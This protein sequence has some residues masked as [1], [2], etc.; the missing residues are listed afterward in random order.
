MADLNKVMLI[1]RLTRDPQLKYLPSQTAICEFGFAVGRQWSTPQGEKREETTFLDCSIFGK[2]AETFN[3]YMAKGRQV[4][5]E[6]RL[7]LDTWD[8]KTTGQKR[9][10]IQVVVENFI[11]LG[12]GQG[13]GG[14]RG[15]GDESGGGGGGYSRPGGYGSDEGGG[16]PPPRQQSRP[17]QRPAPQRQQPADE[18]S[19]VSDEQQFNGDDIPF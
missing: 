11:F 6:G 18:P 16:G 15:G 17:A 13:Q 7:K 9:S 19:P 5:L 2:A 1:G 10:K 3:Q 4:Y 14:P 12:Q 8:D